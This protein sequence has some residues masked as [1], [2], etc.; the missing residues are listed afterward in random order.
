ME[1]T[2]LE[3][4]NVDGNLTLDLTTNINKLCDVSNIHTAW[5]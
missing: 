2:F 4:E 5:E 3:E 1:V